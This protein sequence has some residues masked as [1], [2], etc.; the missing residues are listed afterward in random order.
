MKRYAIEQL[1]LWKDNPNRK[2]LVIRGA[3]QVGKT[4]LMRTF[5]E[6]H[7]AK[8]AYVSF[9]DTPEAKNI[10]DGN[11]NLDNILLGLNVLTNVQIT[12][13]NTLIIF[14]EIQEC[15]RALNVLKFFKENASNYHIIAA[16]SLLGVAVR[17]KQFS[18]P[19]GQVDF[20]N[21]Y[22]LS[23]CEF[24]DGI[25][26][27]ALSKLILEN[28]WSI[29]RNFQDKC[30]NLLKQYM[31]VGGMPEVVQSFALNRDTAEVRRLQNAILSGYQEDF[32]KY[33]EPRNVPKITSVWNSL[34][35]QLAKENKKFTYKDVRK[36]AR[37]REYGTAVEWLTLTG[38]VYKI[39]K[40]TKPNLPI[41]SYE[42]ASTFKLY[43]IDT[44]LLC[45]KAM[46][47]A[48]TIIEGNKIFEEF[49]GALSEQYVLQE[50]K[51]KDN[52]P[53]AY[54]GT[55]NGMA[56][57]DF[58]I[59]D[60]DKVIPIEVKSTINLKAKSLASYRQKYKPIKAVRTS[61]A[62]YEENNGLLNIPLYMIEN[63]VE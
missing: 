26:E 30:I 41:S 3:R 55:S 61:L 56:E 57:I 43:M 37:A 45:A 60:K 27:D 42:N 13:N 19:V 20:L 47:D 40:I 62:G 22:P 7:Y 52:L 58:V 54:W 59:Q 23:F 31:F 50:L 53:V 48:K 39:N 16:G 63:L 10:F 24:L 4:W 34:P 2:P 35:T 32:S 14:D 21:L 46:L 12:P 1:K 17:Q 36:G 38:L 25:G 5:A 6:Q 51:I 49:K 11:Y 29:L 15:E 33:T 9:V 18:F 8:V 28:N 44:G